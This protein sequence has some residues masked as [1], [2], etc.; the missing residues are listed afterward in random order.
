[1]SKTFVITSLNVIKVDKDDYDSL[2]TL[3]KS[4]YKFK[5]FNEKEEQKMREQL[6]TEQGMLLTNSISKEYVHNGDIV[7]LSEEKSHVLKNDAE[8]AFVSSIFG[9]LPE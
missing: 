3:F 1:M 5:S 9:G 6:E 2:Y 4:M 7:I 8:K